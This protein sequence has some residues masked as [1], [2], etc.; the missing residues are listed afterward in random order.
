M[1]AG[2]GL[3]LS[4]GCGSPERHAAR[5]QQVPHPAHDRHRVDDVLDDV[6]QADQVEADGGQIEIL[7]PA[8]EHLGADAL[9]AA[10]GE[11]FGDLHPADLPAA[12][13]AQM[14]EGAAAAADVDQRPHGRVETPK[15]VHDEAPRPSSRGAEAVRYRVECLAR[16]AA[17]VQGRR[18]LT[19]AGASGRM[20]PAR[21][22][23]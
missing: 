17:R 13:L 6:P 11:R 18:P 5:P 8:A 16:V 19:S 15:P 1:V 20:R 3:L 9:A 7:E 23:S 12:L 10:L 14:E 2:I 4:A 22:L 21:P